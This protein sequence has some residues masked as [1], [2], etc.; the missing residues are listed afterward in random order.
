[1]AAMFTGLAVKLG[2]SEHTIKED[3]SGEKASIGNVDAR[4]ISVMIARL[5]IEPHNMNIQ[6]FSLI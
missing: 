6:A 4:A 2:I 3:A 5:L 1:M